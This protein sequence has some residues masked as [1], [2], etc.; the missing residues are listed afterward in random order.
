[1]P[2][3]HPLPSIRRFVLRLGRHFLWATG[4]VTVS[5]G[6]GIVGFRETEGLSW[7]D[8]LLNASM[9]LGGMGPVNVPHT[10]AGKWF[11]SLYALYCG[12]VMLVASGLLLAPVA[13]RIIHRLHIDLDHGPPPDDA[14][15]E[16]DG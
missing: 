12:L 4:L 16:R 1:M 6:A 10:V 13:Q 14:E 3:N 9:L 8:A 15:S 2:R 5:L 7:L 11:A